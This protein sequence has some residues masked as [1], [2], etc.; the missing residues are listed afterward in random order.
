VPAQRL[1]RRHGRVGERLSGF[2]GKASAAVVS[3]DTT[4]S[5]Y[6]VRSVALF[7]ST[8]AAR[9]PSAS[10]NRTTAVADRARTQ[11]KPCPAKEV[12]DDLPALT[13][14]WVCGAAKEYGMSLP[15]Y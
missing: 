14:A 4:R 10:C 2:A 12:C 13:R 7:V 15:A 8:H 5:K 6:K 9:A 1:D 3:I 11:G